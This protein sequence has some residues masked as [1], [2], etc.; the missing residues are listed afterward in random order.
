MERLHEI[1]DAYLSGSLTEFDRERLERVLNDFPTLRSVVDKR[2]KASPPVYTVE[3]SDL[4]P[5]DFIL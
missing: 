2:K 3:D 4:V 1:I 5:A